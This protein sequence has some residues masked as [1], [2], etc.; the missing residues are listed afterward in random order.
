M[1]AGGKMGITQLSYDYIADAV[2]TYWK[3]SYPRDVVAFFW[4]KYD[5]DE[6]WEW[7]E[8]VVFCKSDSD[9]EEVSFLNDFCEGQTQVKDIKIAPLTEIIEHYSKTIIAHYAGRR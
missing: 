1:R 7:C 9:Y 6:K 4:Q 2:R 3:N 8:E 5:Y